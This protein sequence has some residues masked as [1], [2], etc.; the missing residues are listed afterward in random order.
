MVTAPTRDPRIPT[1]EQCAEIQARWAP[2]SSSVCEKTRKNTEPWSWRAEIDALG[3][4][5]EVLPEGHPE[6]GSL[7][8][9]I[10]EIW[11]ANNP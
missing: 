3:Q 11:L 6:R 5:F 2:V 7:A 4:I 9:R 10:R 1:P 8:A